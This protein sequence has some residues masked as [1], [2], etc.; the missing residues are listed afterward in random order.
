MIWAGVLVCGIGCYLLKLAGLSVPEKVL[1]HPVVERIADLMPVAL[2][3]ALIAVQ[4]FSAPGEDGP[5]L[6]VDARLAGLGAAVVA[7]VLRA[8]VIVVVFVAAAT[9]AQRPRP[10]ARAG[11]RGRRA[12]RPA[13]APPPAP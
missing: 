6:V 12:G 3:A 8:P 1:E 13:A 10:G 5:H 9:A 11:P 4:V 7:R 2:L